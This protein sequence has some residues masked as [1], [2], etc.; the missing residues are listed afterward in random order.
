MCNEFRV[1]LRGEQR[2]RPTPFN[3]YN[4]M[5][6]CLFAGAV[7][8]WPDVFWPGYRSR[9]LSMAP[10]E[11]IIIV[12]ITK[13]RSMLSTRH[14]A[15]HASLLIFIELNSIRGMK[16][17]SSIDDGWVALRELNC[18][19]IFFYIY[20]FYLRC[21]STRTVRAGLCA[22]I[23]VCL[24]VSLFRSIVA[25]GYYYANFL[26]VWKNTHKKMW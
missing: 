3:S 23:C 20:L 21:P 4:E 1:F 5:L 16:Q 19:H 14:I 18:S 13:I 9:S 15:S 12:C 17:L 7:R 26:V 25:A 24:C 22:R 2:R 6:M 11:I 10:Y 8:D